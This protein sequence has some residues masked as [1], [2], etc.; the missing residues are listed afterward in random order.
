MAI[1]RW[2]IS[3][4]DLTNSA[5][6]QAGN[7]LVAVANEDCVAVIDAANVPAPRGPYKKREPLKIQ[8]ETLPASHSLRS[9]HSSSVK[10]GAYIPR[11]QGSGLGTGRGGSA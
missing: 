10:R 5:L 1:F 11:G 6:S 4:I 2:P 9:S 3:R 8:T 7:N